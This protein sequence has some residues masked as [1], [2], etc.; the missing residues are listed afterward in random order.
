[1]Y[2]HVVCRGYCDSTRC[3]LFSSY[4]RLLQYTSCLLDNKRATPGLCDKHRSVPKRKFIAVSSSPLWLAERDPVNSSLVPTGSSFRN[5]WRSVVVDTR[6][7]RISN[8][9]FLETGKN[10]SLANGLVWRRSDCC[11]ST[12]A[13]LLASCRLPVPDTV[14]SNQNR[15]ALFSFCLFF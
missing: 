2:V 11:C 9:H 12:C 3:I 4:A 8:L 10:G 15:W 13:P 14:I 1:M 6:K 7:E 5:Y